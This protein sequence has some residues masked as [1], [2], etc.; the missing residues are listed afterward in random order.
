MLNAVEDH[1]RR[2]AQANQ[3]VVCAP[4]IAVFNDA[5]KATKKDVRQ[6]LAITTD[7][8]GTAGSPHEGLTRLEGVLGPATTVIRSGGI[9]V[10]PDGEIEDKLHVHWRLKEPASTAAAVADLQEA[11]RLAAQLGGG[12]PA[13]VP[14]EHPFRWPG[15]WHRK[16]IQ[17]P[18]LCEAITTR[19]DVEI[20]LADPSKPFGQRF[21]NLS[22]TRRL[23]RRRATIGI[24]SPPTSS[25][26]SLP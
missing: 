8:D 7:L 5:L 2:A 10:S 19:P 16:N 14:I 20:D 17:A 26:T 13:S 25:A 1:A 22:P 18:R 15:G 4:I 6:G 12:D 9:W 3:P 11:R 21:H 23:S 24:S